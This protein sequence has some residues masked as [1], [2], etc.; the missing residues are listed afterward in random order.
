MKTKLYMLLAFLFL[1]NF[2]SLQAQQNPLI[3]SDESEMIYCIDPI[4][5]TEKRVDDYVYKLTG[6]NI[7]K[8]IPTASPLQEKFSVDAK[9]ASLLSTKSGTKIKIPANAFT[10]KNGNVVVG[11]VELNFTEMNT[12]LDILLSGIPMR[13]KDSYFESAAMFQIGASQNGTELFANPEAPIELIFESSTLGDDFSYYEYDTEKGKWED[14]GTKALTAS[15][16]SYPQTVFNLFNMNNA[17]TI[18]QELNIPSPSGL[19]IDALRSKDRQYLGKEKGLQL[20]IHYDRKYIPSSSLAY[21]EWSKFNNSNW[22]VFGVKDRKKLKEIERRI[23]RLKFNHSLYGK[24]RG[25]RLDPTFVLDMWMVPDFENDCFQMNIVT[26][27]DTMKIPVIPYTTSKEHQEQKQV[28]RFYNRYKTA[29]SER[30]QNWSK[31]LEA[32]YDQLNADSLTFVNTDTSINIAP[33]KGVRT[34]QIYNFGIGNVDRILKLLSEEILV[35]C[36]DEYGESLTVGSIYI[37]NEKVRTTMQF[38]DR[39][40]QVPSTKNNKA[41]VLLDDGRKM[42]VN[43]KRFSRAWRNQS[44]GI[45]KLVLNDSMIW[46]EKMSEENE[47]SLGSIERGLNGLD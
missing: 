34:V 14:Q 21:S 6:K 15:T 10:D 46:K 24:S 33:L 30:R 29:L 1:F 40:I 4:E 25:N 42:W 47:Y 19:Y 41:L 12:A 13:H 22:Q 16:A 44:D 7:V 23:N 26:S 3:D 8:P 11:K 37:V 31:K 39:L 27:A 43:K 45:M 2:S 36:E 35:E 17:I 38:P 20:K 5:V 9:A 32:Y 18:S 28:L